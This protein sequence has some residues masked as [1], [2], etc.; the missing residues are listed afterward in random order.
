[1]RKLLPIAMIAML[2]LL[3]AA[4]AADPPSRVTI[5]AVFNPI[6]YGENA[7]VNGQLIG[8][9]QS[10]QV[11]S[12]EQSPPPYTDWAPVAQVTTDAQG[13]YSFKLSPTQTMQY[14]TSSQG[15]ASESSVEVDVAPRIAIKASAAG[16]ASI[17]FSGSFAPASPGQVVTVQRRDSFGSWA[18]VGTYTLDATSAFHGRM[19]VH[20]KTILR[21]VFAGDANH[22]AAASDATSAAPSAPRKKKRRRG[23]AS[24]TA[25]STPLITRVA[26]NPATIVAGKGFTLRA[27][28][29]MRGGH[30][31][32]ID[33]RW[34]EGDARDHFTLAPAYRRAKVTF[35]L[36]HRYKAAGTHVLT[37][38]VKGAGPFCLRTSAPDR[39]K[40]VAR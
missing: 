39:P 28:A 1:V 10:G 26:T 27:T 5:V 38:R 7:Y 19:T 25:C 23:H 3:P 30:V 14:R 9:G 4:A 18:T 40:L 29:L 13:Y 37:I 2:A 16:R 6:T 17:R 8:D 33:V 15:T 20:R 11:V 31:Q 36:R 12:L 32:S 21:A 22:L 24:A 35:T 34:G